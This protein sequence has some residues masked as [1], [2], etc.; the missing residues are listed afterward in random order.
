M[1]QTIT[2]V[3]D[4]PGKLRL[5]SVQHLINQVRSAVGQEVRA[6]EYLMRFVELQNK[7]SGIQCDCTHS[8]RKL[9]QTYDKLVH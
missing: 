5:Q 6:R 4:V 1:Y 8:I 9:I 2:G 3:D 7:N